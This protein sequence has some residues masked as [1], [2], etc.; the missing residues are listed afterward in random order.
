MAAE[1]FS[2]RPFN[3]WGVN[4]SE[5][6]FF[7]RKRGASGVSRGR[8]SVGPNYFRGGGRGESCFL[9]LAEGRRV[10]GKEGGDA[11]SSGSKNADFSPG[12]SV[13]G[14]EERNE[15]R[16]KGGLTHRESD[17]SPALFQGGGGTE[18]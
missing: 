15:V 8:T 2:Q 1:K 9:L 16:W 10:Q 17:V 18:N 14:G 7:A 13:R 6:G 12:F 3:A 5:G 4:L 11:L